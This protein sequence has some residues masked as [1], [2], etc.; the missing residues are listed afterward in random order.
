MT[1]KRQ[2]GDDAASIPL[3]FYDSTKQSEHGLALR[4]RKARRHAKRRR[5]AGGTSSPPFISG[6]P[7]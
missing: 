7:P 4:L 2:F 3:R 1:A 5:N 6:G